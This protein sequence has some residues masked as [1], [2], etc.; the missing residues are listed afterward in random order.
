[1]SAKCCS[2]HPQA[3]E[4]DAILAALSF[5]LQNHFRHFCEH[6]IDLGL[7]LFQ[8]CVDL[9]ETGINL[10]KARIG[11]LESRESRLRACL[12]LPERQRF[13]SGWMGYFSYCE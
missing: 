13:L 11:F 1:M 10:I 5:V 7:D 9:I 4:D 6:V 12:V 8:F 3:F 2:S